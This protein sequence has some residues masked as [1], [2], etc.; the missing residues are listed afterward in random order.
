EFEEIDL[1][2]LDIEEKVD[3]IVDKGAEQDNKQETVGTQHPAGEIF[4]VEVPGDKDGQYF[5]QS[6]GSE[7]V[8]RDNI[9]QQSGAERY[10]QACHLSFHECNPDTDNQQK[11]GRH[12]ANGDKADKQHV[13]D[14]CQQDDDRVHDVAQPRVAEHRLIGCESIFL[15]E[16]RHDY[17]VP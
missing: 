7:H 1:R 14:R 11:I 3:E 12:S 10:E 16:Q 2:R 5:C 13:D 17:L 9:E 4:V 6:I 15:A 8:R